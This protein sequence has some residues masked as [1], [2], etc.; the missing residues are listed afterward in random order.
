MLPDNIY[1]SIL[2]MIFRLDIK[3]ADRDWPRLASMA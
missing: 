1:E 3:D 2:E